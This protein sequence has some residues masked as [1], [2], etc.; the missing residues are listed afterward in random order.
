[1]RCATRAPLD[2]M[3]GVYCEDVDLAAPMADDSS[4]DHGVK[5]WATDRDLAERLWT[6][7]E[8]WTGVHFSA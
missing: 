8:A 1:M 6:K 3:G 4:A 7:S 2:G 5:A